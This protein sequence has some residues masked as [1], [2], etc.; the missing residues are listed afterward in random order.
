MKNTGIFLI[1][2]LA[3]LFNLEGISQIKKADKHFKMYNYSRA[4]PYLLEATGDD[5]TEVR[6]KAIQMLADCYR[7]TNNNGEARAWYEK[8]VEINNSNPINFFY[9]GQ[10]YRG[11]G[12]YKKAEEAFL[13]FKLVCPDSLDAQKYYDYC[14]N[15]QEW[16]DL[17]PMAEVKNV[18][19]I[20]TRYS[21]FSPAIY[22]GGIV[23]TSDRMKDQLDETYGWTNF[24]Y[25]NLH[26]TE[27]EYYKNLWS[28]MKP[29][30]LMK[31]NFNQEYHDGP[32]TFTYD[33]KRIY[34]T[35]TL[36]K[37]G[38]K[39][40]DNITTSLLKLFYADIEEGKKVSFQP[41]PF[42]SKNYSTA[43]PAISEDNK[44][45]IFSSDMP[46]GFGGSDLYFSVFENEGWTTPKNLGGVINTVGN[47]VFPYWSGDS[48]LFFAS[49]DHQGYGGLDIFR[50]TLLNDSTW[51]D[52]ENLKAPI[53]SSYDDFGIVLSENKTEGLFSSNRPDGKGSDDIYAF[54]NLKFAP[55]I[56]PPFIVNGYVKE[57]GTLI[58]VKQATI[59][60]FDSNANNVL[61]AKTDSYGYFEAEA[62]YDQIYIA[63]AMKDSFLY[64]C[65]SFRT[66]DDVELM[67]YSLPRDLLLGKIEIELVTRVEIYYDVDKWDIREDAKPPLDSLVRFMKNNPINAELSSHTDCRASAEYNL[68]LS[69]KRANAAVDYIVSQGINAGRI[70]AKGYGES[71]LVNHCADGV[72][73]SDTE[74]QANRRTEFKITGV[75]PLLLLENK[76]D[77][78]VFRSG[79]LINPNLLDADFFDDCM[80]KAGLTK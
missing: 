61:I 9:L 26:Y 59:F 39:D 1:F 65:L 21:E 24:N 71:R 69:Q 23:F 30:E 79:D 76:F 14:V 57:K 51:S 80:K 8:A 11:L 32:A 62:S 20:N 68:N 2:I 28:P 6:N 54:K 78:S 29:S 64:D 36:E 15:I 34:V 22:K 77:L 27:P 46:G 43:H 35:K 67:N 42:N 72:T 47:E 17:P 41:M 25:L 31:N 4:I 56:K 10:A 70:I 66:P 49:D 52:P 38:K 74:H 73:C 75:D 63:K 12:L 16:L 60:I 48:V 7:L 3:F 44:K 58:P 33:S 37:D 5:D 18:E 40:E 13:S 53:N 50:S 45:I 55:K 19:T